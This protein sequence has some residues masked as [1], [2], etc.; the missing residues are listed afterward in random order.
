[1]SASVII[2]CA[3]AL[4]ARV[5]I[6]HYRLVRCAN[7]H[8]Y[9]LYTDKEQ[10]IRLIIT[11]IG[12]I[13]A[14]A[15]ASYAYDHNPHS[16]FV[17]I[18]IAGAQSAPIGSG[19][20]INRLIDPLISKA[21]YPFVNSLRSLPATTLTSHA[22]ALTHYPEQGLVDMEGAAF[23]QSATRLV[24]QEQV[25]L[26][27][28]VSDNSQQPLSQFDISVTPDLIQQQM[29]AIDCV[30]KKM[31]TLSQ[32]EHQQQPKTQKMQNAILQHWRFSQTQQHQLQEL[33]RRWLVI[34]P[35]TCAIENIR[36]AKNAKQALLLLQQHIDNAFYQGDFS[37]TS[38]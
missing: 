26:F 38:I 23:W 4:E 2:S 12:L 30:I 20:L 28:I 10:E 5:L 31:L 34:C 32:N 17:N 25:Q 24:T 19:Y 35:D 29:S 33:C 18:G 22:Q 15:A 14:A 8:A 7:R 16:C 11:G 13:P 21:F 9:P 1:M 36:D 6:D 37:S 27:K 3:T